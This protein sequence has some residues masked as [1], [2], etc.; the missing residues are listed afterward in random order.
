MTYRITADLL[1]ADD[2]TAL[3]ASRAE[4]GLRTIAPRIEQTMTQTRAHGDITGATRD[5][6]RAYVA[7][8]GL[9]AQASAEATLSGAIAAVERLNPGRSARAA[10]RVPSAFLALVLTSP[11]DYQY[12]LETENG[13]QK[14]VLG[15]TLAAFALAIARAAGEG[16]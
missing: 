3:F 4:R 11:T 15:P 10:W 6:Y 8:S 14:A 5:G 16:S 7:G 2:I 1:P 13:G 12:K 9:Q